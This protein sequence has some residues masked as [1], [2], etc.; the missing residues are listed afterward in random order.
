M[1]PTETAIAIAIEMFC[2]AAAALAVRRWW[3]DVGLTKIATVLVGMAGGLTLTF[4]AAQIPGVGHLVG[5]VENVADSATRGI[6]GL[7][8][9]VLIG[10]GVSGLLGGAIL[11]AV[12]GLVSNRANG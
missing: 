3:P 10:V 1:S 6:G 2:G 12:L 7:T 11:M 4:I 9:A 8:L 5:H